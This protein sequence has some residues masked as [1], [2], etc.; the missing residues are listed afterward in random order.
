MHQSGVPPSGSNSSTVLN[1]RAVIHSLNFSEISYFFHRFSSGISFRRIA[2]ACSS[3]AQ[4]S[5]IKSEKHIWVLLVLLFYVFSLFSYFLPLPSNSVL[6]FP[7]F[8]SL[9]IKYLLS[10]FI[11]GRT[12]VILVP[13]PGQLETSNLPP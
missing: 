7:G 8:S 2:L 3:L 5:F 10:G 11:F 1:R 12:T 6:L 4:P 13:I 9:S